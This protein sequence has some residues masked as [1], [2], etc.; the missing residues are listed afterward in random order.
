[1]TSIVIELE[2]VAI[3][4]ESCALIFEAFFGAPMMD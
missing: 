2:P 4:Y 3:R 1:M